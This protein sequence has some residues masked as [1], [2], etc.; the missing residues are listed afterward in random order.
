M[1]AT[2]DQLYRAHVKNLRATDTALKSIVRELNSSLSRSEDKTSDALLKTAMLLLGCWAENRLKKMTFEPNG[3][4]NAERAKINQANSQIEIWKAALETGFRKRHAIPQAD[5]SVALP[6]TPR[7]HYQALLNVVD[8]ELRPVIEA[9][10]KLAH[11]QWSRTLN[12][13]N[14]DFSAA[15]MAQI[16]D[17][18]AHSIKCKMRILEYLAR[19]IQDLV[20]GNQAF[21]R[22]FDPH[23]KNLEYA[24]IEISSKSYANWLLNMRSKYQRGRQARRS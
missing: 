1:A 12:S 16:S 15:L 21:E 22:D 9:R 13:E 18:N 17:E 10:N 11:G 7:S 3:F 23:Y 14:T 6:I 5:L 20:A 24:K 4:S 19:I 8:T 2:T